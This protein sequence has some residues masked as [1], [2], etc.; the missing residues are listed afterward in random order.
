MVYIVCSVYSCWSKS[1]HTR[2]RVVLTDCHGRHVSFSPLPVRLLLLPVSEHETTGQLTSFSSFIL[3][4]LIFITTRI[5]PANR[6]GQSVVASLIFMRFVGCESDR[7]DSFEAH[8]KTETSH[9]AL[10]CLYQRLKYESCVCSA[11]ILELT[12][13]SVNPL[14]RLVGVM[15]LAWFTHHDQ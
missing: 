3:R 15:E 10:V 5:L 7:I 6:V 9:P 4:L 12:V 14:I 8:L 2:A 13:F 11:F 1:K